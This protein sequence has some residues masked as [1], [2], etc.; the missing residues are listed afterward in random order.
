MEKEVRDQVQA[1]SESIGQ[2]LEGIIAFLTRLR[3]TLRN[4]ILQLLG[5]HLE[6]ARMAKERLDELIRKSPPST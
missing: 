1:A 4:E 3:P 6:K 2:A 5:D